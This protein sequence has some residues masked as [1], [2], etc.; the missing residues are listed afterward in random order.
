MAEVARDNGVPFV[1]LFAP[2]QQMFAAAAKRRQSLTINGLHLT[3]DGDKI[4]ARAIVQA[5][6]SGQT[7]AGKSEVKAQDDERLRSAVIEKITSGSSVTAPLTATTS[8]ADARNWLTP[9]RK[10]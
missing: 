7:L 3:E 10:T 6:A 1:D 5:F 4:L 2:S 8:M 9:P